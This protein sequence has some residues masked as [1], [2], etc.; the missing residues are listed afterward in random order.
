VPKENPQAVLFSAS[1][2]YTMDSL[3]GYNYTITENAGIFLDNATNRVGLNGTDAARNK[4]LYLLDEMCVEAARNF[5]GAK[6]LAK[7]L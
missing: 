7:W 3:T 4:R 5:T 1:A 6:Y 2:T